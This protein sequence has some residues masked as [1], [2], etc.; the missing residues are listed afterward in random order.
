MHQAE[1]IEYPEDGTPAEKVAMLFHE[2]KYHNTYLPSGTAVTGANGFRTNGAPRQPGAPFADPCI[3][4]NGDLIQKGKAPFFIGQTAN[5]PKTVQFDSA[6]PRR[7]KGA[8]IQI[9]AI[10]N[11]VGW[12]HPQQRIISLWEDVAPTLAG[13]RP[14]EPFVMRLNTLDCAEFWHTNLVPSIYELDDYQVRTPTDIIGQH[15][16]LVKFDVTSSD[17]SGNG[18]NYED[19][20]FSPDEVRERISAINAAGGLQPFEG[21]ECGGNSDP[22]KQ[23]ITEDHP[24]FGK[25]PNSRW[26]GARTTIQRWFMDPVLDNQGN[27]RTLGTVFTHDHFGPSS[28]QQVGLYA[29]LLVEPAGSTWKHN[30]TGVALNTR[31]DGGPTTWQAAILSG[32]NS[33]REFF[34]EWSDFQH[35]YKR[36]FANPNAR[37]DENSYKLA[38]NPSFRVEPINIQDILQFPGQCP[39]PVGVVV[40]RPCP[41][42]IAVSDI[43]TYV[44]NYRNEPV[45]LR[46]FDPSTGGQAPGKAGDLAYAF[47][48]KITRTI[49]DLNVRMPASVRNTTVTPQPF[50]PDVSPQ[51]TG[52]S[53]GA[54]LL[55]PQLTS[56]VGLRDPAT[57]IARVYEGDPVRIK[58]QVG[59][60]EESH[61]VSIHGTKWL[62]EPT[63]PASGWRNSQQMGIDE[64]FQLKMPITPDKNQTGG[65][66]DYLYSTSSSTSG[67]WN[68]TWGFIRSYG[69]K[70]NDLYPLPNSLI[71]RGDALRNRT[72]F[73]NL[74]DFRGV[75]PIK[76]PIR[77]FDLTVVRAADAL[78]TSLPGIGNTLI[79][80]NRADTVAFSTFEGGT[81]PLHDP[82]AMLYVLTSDLDV[83][84]KL[85]ANVPIEPLIV[86]ANAGDCIEVTLRNKLT[87]PVPDLVGWNYVPPV[88]ID[89]GQNPKVT[90]NLN[91]VR[92]SAYVGIHPQLVEYDI[93][94]GDGTN[95]GNNPDQTA[96]P[97]GGIQ[98][99]RWYAGDLSVKKLS[100][101]KLQ[102]VATPVEFGGVGLMP[103]DKIEQANKGLMGALVILPR[104]STWKTNYDLFLAGQLPAGE[105]VTRDTASVTPPLP[106]VPFRDF[107]A[108]L[109]TSVQMRY[110]NT[111][112]NNPFGVPV[113]GI[114]GEGRFA[115]AFEDSG[116]KGINYRIEPAWFRLGFPPQVPF[117]LQKDFETGGLYSNQ[118]VRPGTAIAIG[119]PQTPIFTATAKTP[120]RFHVIE[121]VGG[122]R[123]ATFTLHGHLWDR[124]P[125]IANAT[126]GGPDQI[127][128]NPTS[129]R[130]G[131]QEG[132]G[133]TSHYD[134]VPRNGAGGYFGVAGDYLYRMM[135]SFHNF[136]GMWGLFRVK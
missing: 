33:H 28:H 101:G 127:G 39:G 46:I 94:R 105:R 89:N 42:A 76:A 6:S 111:D 86:R 24:F 54:E 17:G 4:D 131:A 126:L 112:V 100:S 67:Y 43:G 97:N 118:Q 16:H 56:D 79:Y 132:V 7:Y 81:G 114:G 123:N 72:D 8:N 53:I 115:E 90:F 84:G 130:I 44:T 98:K 1:A 78:S 51:S 75:C 134:I 99:Y 93:T 15:I 61:N 34:F 41:E 32:N 135:D 95:V 11:K 64:Q 129:Q 27:D 136:D 58:V 57:P 133:P 20:T 48:S 116:Q 23:L 87:D 12:H 91:D 13:T 109:Q 29:T 37:I 120:V 40:P 88:I 38:I 107:V 22:C 124:M 82:T 104:G 31:H 45:G 55:S 10:F 71:L 83:N 26:V 85:K 70:R 102:F 106:G 68:G 117:D 25:G 18:F 65:A 110:A 47:S 103:A 74:S 121:P 69:G 52:F 66:V 5:T 35:A 96:L 30:E 36:E 59:A 60:T 73:V 63:N 122:H 3:D 77:N 125:Y 9:D 80:N 2:I 14:P 108:V 119:E 19:G 49:P 50:R 21:A 128:N 113:A 92:P 62:Q